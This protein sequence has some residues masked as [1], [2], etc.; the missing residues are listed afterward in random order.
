[1]ILDGVLYSVL[2]FGRVILYVWNSP[3]L[4]SLLNVFY[5]LFRSNLIVY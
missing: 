1:M 2:H 4:V 3:V 5:D